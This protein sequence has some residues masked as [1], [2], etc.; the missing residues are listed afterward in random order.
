MS[1]IP[2]W[3]FVAA[4]LIIGAGVGF[5][6]ERTIKNGDIAQIQLADDKAL[7]EAKDAKI[8]ADAKTAKKEREGQDALS[9]LAKIYEDTRQNEKA[10]SDKRI[11]DLQSGA[12]RLRVSTGPSTANVVQLPGASVA[13]SG[14]DGGPVETLSG[15]VAARLAGRYNAYNEIVDQLTLCQGVILNDRKITAGTP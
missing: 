2:T 12:V 9:D 15:S 8:A 13:A 7:G 1:L 10:Q 14:G 5:D 3:P 11:A 4:A 6:A